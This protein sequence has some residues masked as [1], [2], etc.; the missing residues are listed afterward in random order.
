VRS[1]RDPNDAY[2]ITS[3]AWAMSVG[4]MSIPGSFAVL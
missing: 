1:L 4:G 2:A 3:S